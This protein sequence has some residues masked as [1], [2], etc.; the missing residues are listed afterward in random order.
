[1]TSRRVA[2]WRQHGAAIV[3]TARVWRGYTTS[4]NRPARPRAPGR[5][6]SEQRGVSRLGGLPQRPHT[7]THP[8]DT[9]DQGQPATA[10]NT[11][12]AAWRVRFGAEK[13]GRGRVFL[14][15]AWREDGWKRKINMAPRGGQTG[16]SSS[17][18]SQ[19]ATQS[20]PLLLLGGGPHQ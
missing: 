13:R 10:W 9:D 12:H 8:H 1:M 16:S 17:S 6:A 2:V 20:E 3:S 5:P 15:D 18:S 19:R 4:D 11:A 14:M 7:H